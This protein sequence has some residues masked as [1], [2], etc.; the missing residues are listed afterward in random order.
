MIAF[1]MSAMTPPITLSRSPF[2]YT[3]IKIFR[4]TKITIRFW[5]I[6]VSEQAMRCRNRHCDVF[7]DVKRDVNHTDDVRRRTHVFRSRLFDYSEAKIFTEY[8]KTMCLCNMYSSST[9]LVWYI[10]GNL[11]AFKGRMK[12]N[13]LKHITPFLI[14]KSGDEIRL[15]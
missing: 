6:G 7:S 10:M 13:G 1:F 3:V 15:R 4:Q 5:Y 8:G 9:A 2:I 11:F 12:L 14:S